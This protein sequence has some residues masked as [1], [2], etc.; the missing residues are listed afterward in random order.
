MSRRGAPWGRWGCILV[1]SVL[2]LVASP[3]LH[4]VEPVNGANP[5]P[6][7]EVHVSL[8]PDDMDA[9]VSH[10]DGTK[11]TF[12]GNVTVY[13]PQWMNTVVTLTGSTTSG[14]NVTI[15]P[16]PIRFGNSGTQ[17]FMFEVRV[18][19]GTVDDLVENVTVRA[20][21]KAPIL[22][23]IIASDTATVTVENTSPDPVWTVRITE[24]APGSTFEAD[25]LTIKG[26]AAFNLGDVTE[27]EVKV[28]TGPWTVATGTTD[29]SIDYDCSYLT[30]GQ[31]TVYARARSGG[32]VS[33][34][35]EITVTQERPTSA[36][37]TQ[38]GSDPGGTTDGGNDLFWPLLVAILVLV[39]SSVA[40][41]VHNRRRRADFEYYS[42]YT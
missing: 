2:I 30:D 28:C 20:S 18:P 8:F 40:Y 3:G 7:P 27:V 19:K 37:D 29:W 17:R 34:A 4:M 16:N 33:P 12:G 10:E 36:P 15:Y 5:G 14:W 39:V 42:P 41:Y 11:V 31:H 24:P 9:R 35:T 22:A 25:R 32:E 13:Q 1:A 38:P 21:C 23:P 26:T 6:I